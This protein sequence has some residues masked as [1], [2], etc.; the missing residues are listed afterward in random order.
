VGI[1]TGQHGR[2][3][4]TAAAGGYKGACKSYTF[5]GEPVQIVSPYRWMTETPEITVTKIVSD[6]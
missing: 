5:F 3:A 4:W 6:N 2:S 1:T